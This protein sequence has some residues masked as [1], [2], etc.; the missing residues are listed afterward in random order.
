MSRKNKK[1]TSFGQPDLTED[2]PGEVAN[3]EGVIPAP[4]PSEETTSKIAV[5]EPLP[6][7]VEAPVAPS[8]T[9]SAK[10]QSASV[11]E[12]SAPRSRSSIPDPT[13]VKETPTVVVKEASKPSVSRKLVKTETNNSIKINSSESIKFKKEP[14]TH[15]NGGRS[16][17][18]Y[19][20]NGLRFLVREGTNDQ[21]VVTSII[22]NGEYQIKG[23][24]ECNVI[25]DLGAHIGSYGIF[26]L[27]YMKGSKGIALEPLPENVQLIKLNAELNGV[28]DRL[29]IINGAVGVG[30]KMTISSLDPTTDSGK[31]HEF[32][33]NRNITSMSHRAV[34]VK[35]YTLKM[36][37]DL[38]ESKW[39]FKQ[40]SVIKLDVEGTEGDFFR[41]ASDEELLRVDWFV[42]EYHNGIKDL[43]LERFI[44]LGFSQVVHSMKSDIFLLKNPQL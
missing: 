2:T 9:V 15:L 44:K 37:L 17:S 41:R 7:A 36:L 1:P 12:L 34:E 24:T 38:V 29:E 19:I 33:G 26:S 5:T 6:V 43:N 25:V 16:V 42:G 30:D 10:P 4:T 11:E 22:W 3:T 32:I 14:T 40:V 18:E 28:A 13:P 23:L 21:D 20:L 27:A 8:P 35:V 39:G 31:M